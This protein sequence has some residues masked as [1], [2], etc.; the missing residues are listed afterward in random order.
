MKLGEQTNPTYINQQF[1]NPFGSSVV[2]S[3]LI[4]QSYTASYNN[5]YDGL[6][7]TMSYGMS[8]T[9]G[10]QGRDAGVPGTFASSGPTNL[11]RTTQPTVRYTGYPDIQCALAQL[12]SHEFPL[13]RDLHRACRRS[14]LRRGDAARQGPA[15]VNVTL[16][17]CGAVLSRQRHWARYRHHRPAAA[18]VHHTRHASRDQPG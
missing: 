10:H 6:T 3:P 7:G 15:R 17:G 1:V 2:F 5:S 8:G 9:T 11:H 12:G 18:N 4:V 16:P 14:A 13:Q